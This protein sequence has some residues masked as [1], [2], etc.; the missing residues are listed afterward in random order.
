MTP[1]SFRHSFNNH[2][3]SSNHQ[4]SPVKYFK[5]PTQDKISDYEDIWQTSPLPDHDLLVRTPSSRSCKGHEF[6]NS[7]SSCHNP[8]MVSPSTPDQHIMKSPLHDSEA[9]SPSPCHDNLI[10]PTL[11]EQRFKQ[12]LFNKVFD[13]NKPS[14]SHFETETDIND[15]TETEYETFE[16]EEIPSQSD[17]SYP[18]CSSSEIISSSD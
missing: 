12:F 1:T 10:S 9:C 3:S 16:T 18:T 15:E 11:S 6:M 5:S 17:P 14:E 2:H 13:K 7:S 8:M 4:D